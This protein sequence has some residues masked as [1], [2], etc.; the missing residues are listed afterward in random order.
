VPE[1][2]TTEER[3]RDRGQ[4]GKIGNEAEGAIG[5]EFG[6]LAIERSDA[7]GYWVERD[8]GRGWVLRVR[9]VALVASMA[10]LALACPVQSVGQ[11]TGGEQ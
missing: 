5:G 11:A 1:G 2:H 10:S 6:W 3:Q 7:G 9:V 4:R 8:W